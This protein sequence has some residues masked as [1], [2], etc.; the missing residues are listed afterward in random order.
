MLSGVSASGGIN[1]FTEGRGFMAAPYNR[2]FDGMAGVQIGLVNYIGDNPKWARV[3]PFVN[4]HL[5]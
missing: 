1:R 4:L 3:L 2:I 5:D